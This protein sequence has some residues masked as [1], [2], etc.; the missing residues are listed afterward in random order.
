MIN[1]G[2][3]YKDISFT[4]REFTNSKQEEKISITDDKSY[5]NKKKLLEHKKLRTSKGNKTKILPFFFSPSFGIAKYLVEK[6]I[7]VV[8]L[9]MLRVRIHVYIYKSRTIAAVCVRKMEVSYF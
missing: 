5:R 3:A 1:E 2:T 8:S 4:D 7:A 9:F 6:K